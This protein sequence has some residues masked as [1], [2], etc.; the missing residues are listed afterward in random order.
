MVQQYRFLTHDW[1]KKYTSFE[2]DEIPR[3][4]AEKYR[5]QVFCKHGR[6]NLNEMQL[7]VS[8]PENVYAL[9]QHRFANYDSITTPL[10]ECLHCIE[11]QHVLKTESSDKIDRAEVEKAR[12]KKLYDKKPLRIQLHEEY[13]L[14]PKSI[15]L[16][17]RRL[18]C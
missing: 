18:C 4:D 9:L 2:E 7:H 10:E 1:R 13:N 17:K 16:V 8:I 3:P 6:A 12:L 15:Y 11:E 5:K 14:I